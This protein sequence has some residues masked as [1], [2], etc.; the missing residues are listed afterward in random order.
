MPYTSSFKKISQFSTPVRLI[1]FIGAL[2]CLWLPL[3]IPIY[4]LLREDSNLVSILTMMLLFGELLVLWRFWG[5]LV[6]GETH[7]FAHYGLVSNTKNGRE[8][9][10]G[11]AIGFW[12]CLTLFILEVLVG[13]IE[14]VTP[15]V[16][17]IKITAEGFFSAVGI[18]L[19]EE[20]LF[21]GWLLD[22]LQRDYE[23]KI[24]LWVSAIAYAIAHFFK[25][26]EEI[27]RTAVTFP[28][29]V[30]LGIAL[31]LAKYRHGDRLGICIGIHAGLVW[32]YYIVNVGHLVEYTHRVPVWVTGIDNNPIAGLIGLFFLSG[33]TLVVM[34]RDQGK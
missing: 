2:S 20:L 16:N 27:I 1:I 9:L 30:L 25:P 11:L 10:Q 4:W 32:G 22:E 7:I 14:V 33:L 6:H 31:V 13:W 19:A 18:S 21:R 28:A 29:L 8:F 12:L 17:L 23:Q 15:S 24:C 3:A 26:L 5:R 34:S